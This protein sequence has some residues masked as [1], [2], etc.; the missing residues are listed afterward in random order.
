MYDP[1]DVLTES[2]L[3]QH[4]VHIFNM[5]QAIFWLIN[6]ADDLHIGTSHKGDRA[7]DV[8]YNMKGLLDSELLQK[9]DGEEIEE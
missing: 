9:G 6:N 7:L 1:K 2:G 5:K 4:R 3:E 8:I